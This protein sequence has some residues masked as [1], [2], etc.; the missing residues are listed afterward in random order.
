MGI[1]TSI[2][3]KTRHNPDYVRFVFSCLTGPVEHITMYG[4]RAY[5]QTDWY[6]G[7]KIMRSE[8]IRAL[9]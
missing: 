2:Q 7:G 8:N 9:V 4:P 1:V 5:R 3:S 6:S